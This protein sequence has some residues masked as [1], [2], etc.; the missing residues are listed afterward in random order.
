MSLEL[1]KE[2][3]VQALCAHY[4]Q[5]HLSTGE[6]ESRFERVNASTDHDM[7]RTALEGLPTVGPLVA[8]PP[9]LRHLASQPGAS[10]TR[11]DDQPQRYAAVFSQ[12]TKE[13]HWTPAPR[14]QATACLGGVT[15]DLRDADIPPEGIH[16]EVNS[17]LG[18][19]KIILPPGVGADVDCTAVM[20]EV[21]DK[22][23]QGAP[24]APRVRVT[25][26]AVMG[27]IVVMTKLPRSSGM[28]SWR[29]R[30]KQWFGSD[31]S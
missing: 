31:G 1:E 22:A 17:W 20:A 24:G 6:L 8:P 29:A 14:I 10:L 9:A 28:E 18:E 16:M 25:G 2:R 19:M 4:A 26:G 15:L 5:D 7:L 27:N 30:L 3:V 21:S 23:K 13:G 12:I 11:W